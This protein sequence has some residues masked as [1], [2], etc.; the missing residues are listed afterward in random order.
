[1][2]VNAV[3]VTPEHEQAKC[4]APVPHSRADR[5]EIGQSFVGPHAAEEPDDRFGGG[6]FVREKV[7]LLRQQ[8]VEGV[9]DRVDLPGVPLVVSP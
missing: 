4:Q 1:V 3:M 2:R 9:V 7:Q 5:E 8:R 6:A